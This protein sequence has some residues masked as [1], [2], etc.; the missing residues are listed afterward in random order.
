MIT[1]AGVGWAAGRA[2][3]RP[4]AGELL[5]KELHARPRRK[6]RIE[7]RG[8][9]QRG[10]TAT[11]DPDGRAAAAMRLRVHGH[12]VEGKVLAVEADVV[13]APQGL[14]DLEELEDAAHAP[15]EGHPH[16][17]ELLADVRHVPRDTYAQ[18]DPSFRDAIK[19]ADDVGEDHG[20]AKR[21]QEH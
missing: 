18:D 19:G 14:A 15:L 10:G 17:L 4:D 16:V 13:A 11:P 8:L 9:A 5:G 7:A 20:L 12:V 3:R 1:A 21:G 2:G 6:P